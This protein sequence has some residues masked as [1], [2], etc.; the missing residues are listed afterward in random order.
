MLSD[1]QIA[2][3][4]ERGG[5]RWWLFVAAAYVTDW[6]PVLVSR[7]RYAELVNRA[8]GFDLAYDAWNKAKREIAELKDKYEPGHDVIHLQ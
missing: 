4:A 3:M 1:V 2:R 5:P 8:E 6:L 7:D